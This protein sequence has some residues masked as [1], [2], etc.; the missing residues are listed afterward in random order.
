MFMSMFFLPPLAYYCCSPNNE[1]A[2]PFTIP[3]LAFYFG[4]QEFELQLTL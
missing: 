1:A 4:E 3:Q 2:H